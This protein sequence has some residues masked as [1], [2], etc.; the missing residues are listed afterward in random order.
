MFLDR[1]ELVDENAGR[2]LPSGSVVLCFRLVLNFVLKTSFCFYLE[3]LEHGVVLT[4]YCS[5]SIALKQYPHLVQY[6]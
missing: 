4:S 2:Y 1:I 5:T 3:S 6:S